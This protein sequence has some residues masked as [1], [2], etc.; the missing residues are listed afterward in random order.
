MILNEYLKKISPVFPKFLID[1]EP[2]IRILINE[3]S[4]A[5]RIPKKNLCNTKKLNALTF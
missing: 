4:L 1:T 3:N 2:M 5:S